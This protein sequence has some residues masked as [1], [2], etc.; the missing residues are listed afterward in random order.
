MKDNLKIYT[1][2]ANRLIEQYE[3]LE[4]EK[5]HQDWLEY[6][7]E[8]RGLAI[9]IGAGSGR[10]AAWLNSLGFKVFAVE[11]VKALRQQAEKIH[12]QSDITWINDT[13][14]LLKKVFTLSKSFNL[15]LLGAVWMHL[16]KQEQ[17]VSMQNLSKL[18]KPDGVVVI[19]LRFGPSP[20]ERIMY[21]ID[22]ETLIKT[23]ENVGFQTILK[24]RNVDLF[25]REGVSWKTLILKKSR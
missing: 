7:P 24:S 16:T 8:Y 10:D 6:T 9:D 13:L 3:S 14:P 5:V 19:T 11:P 15:I 21:P 2:Y 20:D 18:T 4:P 12:Y 25:N 22:T 1:K 17:I 23:A